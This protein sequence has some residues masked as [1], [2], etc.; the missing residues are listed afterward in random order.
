[1]RKDE[2]DELLRVDGKGLSG[3]ERRSADEHDGVCD[4]GSF[5][6]VSDGGCS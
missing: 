3:L 6:G 5:A 1:M 2:G 4:S